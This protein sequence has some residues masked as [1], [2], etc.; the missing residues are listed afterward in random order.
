MKMNKNSVRYV[1]NNFYLC[2]EC[3]YSLFIV[4]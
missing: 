3:K 4:K 2:Y 1:D